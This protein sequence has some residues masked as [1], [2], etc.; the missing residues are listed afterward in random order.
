VAEIGFVILAKTQ[1]TGTRKFV[2][3]LD[4]MLQEPAQNIFLKGKETLD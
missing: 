2:K 4:A 1:I 3:C